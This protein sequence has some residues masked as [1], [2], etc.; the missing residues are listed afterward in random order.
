MP[1]AGELE[2]ELAER[3]LWLPGTD[4]PLLSMVGEESSQPR[5]PGKFP[6]LRVVTALPGSRG[7][8]ARGEG[9]KWRA[10][11]GARGGISRCL[12]SWPPA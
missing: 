7:V 4:E 10:E 11:C 2:G 9:G 1:G 12:L 3:D 6:H 8:A 5:R